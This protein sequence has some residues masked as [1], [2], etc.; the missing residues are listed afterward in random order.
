MVDRPTSSGP[1]QSD[2]VPARSASAVPEPAG[3]ESACL[4]TLVCAECGAL[5]ERQ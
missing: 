3:G 1:E 4:L 5:V 2:Q